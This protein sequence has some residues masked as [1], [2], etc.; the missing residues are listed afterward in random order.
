[1]IHHKLA[2]KTYGLLDKFCDETWI[3]KMAVTEKILNNYL[4]N[5][6]ISRRKK[7]P[8]RLSYKSHI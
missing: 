8:V 2:M 6:L 7:K 4:M 5:N 1:M 3:T